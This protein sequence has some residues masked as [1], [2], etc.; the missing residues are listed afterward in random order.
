MCDADER[1]PSKI[2]IHDFVTKEG[3]IEVNSAD[4]RTDIK[5]PRVGLLE[6]LFFFTENGVRTAIQCKRNRQAESCMFRSRF[7]S[8]ET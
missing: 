1:H 6:T 5:S 3:K 4:E 8:F 7:L 2:I